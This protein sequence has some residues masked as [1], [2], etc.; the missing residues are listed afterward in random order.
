M[1]SWASTKTIANKQAGRG[2]PHTVNRRGH[3]SMDALAWKTAPHF[4]ISADTERAELYGTGALALKIARAQAI[5]RVTAWYW[6][7]RDVG[8][9]RAF[10]AVHFDMRSLGAQY[11]TEAE[12]QK[13]ISDMRD[14]IGAGPNEA[15]RG[16]T[17]CAA[18]YLAFSNIL[19]G[20]DSYIDG[21]GDI[22]VEVAG[23]E[24]RGLTTPQQLFELVGLTK[25]QW[26]RVVYYTS[27]R[28]GPPT[29]LQVAKRIAQVARKKW[30]IDV[31]AAPRPEAP[32]YAGRV[33]AFDQAPPAASIND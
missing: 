7:I 20:V 13:Y 19:P 29:A 30:G 28:K 33:E 5:E 10:R 27:T 14:E 25:T 11:E 21:F 3:G 12:R 31:T 26:L 4:P 24:F 32:P 15:W 8:E 16:T 23:L 17:G 2:N 22:R 18:C 9:E 6:L 1:S